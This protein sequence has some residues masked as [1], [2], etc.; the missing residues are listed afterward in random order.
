MYNVWGFDAVELR[1]A[2]SAVFRIGTDEPDEL[3]GV[4]ALLAKG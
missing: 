3:S 4:L 1:M 2:S